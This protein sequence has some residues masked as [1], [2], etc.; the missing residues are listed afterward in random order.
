MGRGLLGVEAKMSVTVSVDVGDLDTRERL[1]R[2]AT[3][4]FLER[5]YGGTRV[6]DIAR[7]AGYTSGALYQHFPSRTALLAEAISHAG[8]S[9]MEGLIEVVGGASPGESAV[10]LALAHFGTASTTPVDRLLLEALALASGDAESRTALADAIGRLSSRLGD[11]VERAR[12]NGLIVAD[13]DIEALC[14]VFTSW[15]L[16]TVV[17]KAVGSRGVSTERYLEV[18]QMLLAGLTPVAVSGN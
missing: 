17:L 9:I 14:M 13:V 16:G 18:N 4:V 6:Q 12:Q 7:R 2:A 11:Q 10:A 3:E 5:G 8:L 1:V 15:L